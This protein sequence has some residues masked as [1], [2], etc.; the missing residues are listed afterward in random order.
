MSS[1]LCSCTITGTE[2]CNKFPYLTV[3][4]SCQ[5]TIQAHR[6]LLFSPCAVLICDSLSL[7]SC[8]DMPSSTKCCSC[9]LGP[10]TEQENIPSSRIIFLQTA[11]ASQA[12]MLM[13]SLSASLEPFFMA[14]WKVMDIRL[15]STWWQH[16]QNGWSQGC[17]GRT[18]G[19]YMHW[20]L[21]C[22]YSTWWTTVILLLHYVPHNAASFYFPQDDHSVCVMLQ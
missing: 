14:P 15:F 5:W 17:C 12:H 22:S 20:T 8:T 1:S 18:H 13:Y 10:R 9:M 6:P 3:W 4:F 21:I 7:N 2:L 19:H 11:S 16:W